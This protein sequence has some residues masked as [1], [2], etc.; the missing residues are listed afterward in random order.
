MRVNTS[1]DALRSRL[2]S[3]SLCK[4]EIEALPLAQCS[5]APHNVAI[6]LCMAVAPKHTYGS[7]FGL[8]FSG[9]FVWGISPGD[10]PPQLTRC[11]PHEV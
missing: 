4:T 8:N 10:Y 6:S 7:F 2:N 9:Q 1:V 11:L 5:K 3:Q